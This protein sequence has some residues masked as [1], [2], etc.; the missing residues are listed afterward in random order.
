MVSIGARL[1]GELQESSWSWW[2]LAVGGDGAAPSLPSD[3][4]RQGRSQ[5]ASVVG[6]VGEMRE[7]T[8]GHG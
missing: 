8:V 7:M 4:C 6:C 5:W 3:M 2:P 1:G